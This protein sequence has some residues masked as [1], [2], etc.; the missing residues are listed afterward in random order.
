MG[1]AE[2]GSR[3]ML[4]VK[5]QDIARRESAMQHLSFEYL[6]NL[7]CSRP[8]LFGRLFCVCRP[9]LAFG[10]FQELLVLTRRYVWLCAASCR[11]Y[12]GSGDGKLQ[13]Q[14]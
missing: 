7:V 9:E 5:L 2:V 10:F 14:D 1:S 4:D 11:D 13:K 12:A 3:Q 8:D 6:G